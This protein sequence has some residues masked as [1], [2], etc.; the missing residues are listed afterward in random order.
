M[1]EASHPRLSVVRQCAL[2][3][4]SRSGHDYQPTGETEQTLALM[5]LP[6]ARISSGIDEV[7]G[8]CPYGGSRQMVRH[9]HRLGHWVGR[10]QVVRLIRQVGL[11]VTFQ[12][13]NTRAPHP[14]H[15]VP[16]LPVAGSCHRAA[17]PGL[18]LRHHLH[19]H[20]RRTSR[21]DAAGFLNRVGF[22]GGSNS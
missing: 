18:V 14:E 19:S 10:A 13:P 8:E 16:S 4:I 22:T 15:R 1:I 20:V 21:F 6:E 9:L 7:L 3:G 17:R 12:K 5:R 11:A 2:L